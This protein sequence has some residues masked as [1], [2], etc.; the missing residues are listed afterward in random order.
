MLGVELL[1]SFWISRYYNLDFWNFLH[2]FA[3]KALWENFK[4][5]WKAPYFSEIS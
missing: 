1:S 2:D 5:I 4:C 3:T